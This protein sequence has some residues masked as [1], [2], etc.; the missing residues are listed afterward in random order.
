MSGN[1]QSSYFLEDRDKPLNPRNASLNVSL[2]TQY[3]DLDDQDDSLYA[4]A[5]RS[6]SKCVGSI[7]TPRQVLGLLRVLKA[8]TLCF[9]VLTILSNLVYIL[10]VEFLSAA[11]VKQVAGGSRDTVLRVYALGLSLLGL[12]VELDYSKVMKKFS[13]LKG[14]LPRA[15]LYFF[16]AQLTATRRLTILLKDN[17]NNQQQAYQNDDAA[18]AAGDDANGGGGDD[19]YNNAQSSSADITEEINIPSSAIGFQRVASFVL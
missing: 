16:I 13:G 3:L 11:E 14:F 2:Q 17:S 15:L 6:I 7:C 8:V 12:A 18:E 19:A 1:W 10:F 9:L 5:T 4:N